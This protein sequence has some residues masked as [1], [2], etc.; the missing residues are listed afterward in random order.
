MINF[1][2]KDFDKIIPVGREPDLKLSWYYLTDGDL[3]LRFAEQTIYEYSTE[4]MQFFGNKPTPFNDYYIVRFLEDFS[5]LFQS[6]SESIPRNLYKLT[7]NLKQFRE[8]AQKWLDINDTDDDKYD[9]FYFNK[10]DRLIS[11]TYNRMINSGHLIGGPQISFFKHHDKIRIVWNTEYTLENGISLWTAKDGNF[12][13][14]FLDFVNEIRIFGE[15]FFK[16]MESQIKLTIAKEWDT[17]IIDKT[18]LIEEHKERQFEFDKNLSL[19][20]YGTKDETNWAEI[21][22]LFDQMKNEI[23]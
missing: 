8:D 2:L 18:R 1:K 20:E 9:D 14:N 5:E 17:I 4:A 10:Y 12:E 21:E 23:K 7:E 11:W 16:V 3:W 19:L 22:E 13:M 15:H 6:I